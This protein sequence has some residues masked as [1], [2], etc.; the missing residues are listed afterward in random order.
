MCVYVREVTVTSNRKARSLAVL[1]LLRGS[2]G[3]RWHMV[4]NPGAF[5]RGHRRSI[6]EP[7]Q[8]KQQSLGHRRPNEEPQLTLGKETKTR[9]DL[10]LVRGLQLIHHC[11]RQKVRPYKSQAQRNVEYCADF[12]DR[13]LCFGV[14]R[15]EVCH[16]HTLVFKGTM[17]TISARSKS[18]RCFGA[19]LTFS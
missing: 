3:V 19:T 17:C 5:N 8:Q 12:F 4:R 7:F 18:A 13:S 15:G 10:K 9:K 11:P 6:L 1:S 2:T 16:A 14:D